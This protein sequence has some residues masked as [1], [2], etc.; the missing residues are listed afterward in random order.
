MSLSAKEFDLLAINGADEEYEAGLRQRYGI[1]AKT[2]ASAFLYYKDGK[3][4]FPVKSKKGGKWTYNKRLIRAALQR[5][6][7]TSPAVQDAIRGKLSRLA[8][9]YGFNP[10]GGEKKETTLSPQTK[11]EAKAVYNEIETAFKALT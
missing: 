5:F 10:P 11:I 3:G 6:H 1:G 2:P 7:Q 8:K 9:R 4:K